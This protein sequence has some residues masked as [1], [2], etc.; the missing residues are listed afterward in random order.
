MPSRTYTVIM[1]N[2]EMPQGKVL[3]SGLTYSIATNQLSTWY[4]IW[5]T[6]GFALT[7]THNRVRAEKNEEVKEI[8]FLQDGK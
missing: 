7:R 3:E 6:K 4:N 5:R 8:W 2:P 1:K